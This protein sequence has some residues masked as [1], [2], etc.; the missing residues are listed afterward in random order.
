MFAY[1]RVNDS[2]FW[3]PLFF[4]QLFFCSFKEENR[5][6]KITNL[7]FFKRKI[8][9]F[10]KENHLPFVSFPQCLSAHLA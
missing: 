4:S 7:F 6:K 9:N 10:Q 2:E 3:N 8:I 1:K 5:T